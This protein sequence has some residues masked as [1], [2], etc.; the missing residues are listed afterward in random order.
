MKITVWTKSNCVQCDMTKKELTKRGIGYEEQ[1]LE[2]NPLVLE[3]FKQQGL[4]AAP[5]VTTDI[6]AWSGFRL[7]KIKSLA[8]YLMGE[9]AHGK[10]DSN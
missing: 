6:K 1:S 10:K 8:N 7:D 4:L 9:N 5:I 2:D 3:G